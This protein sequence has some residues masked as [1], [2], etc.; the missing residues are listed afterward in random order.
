MLYGGPTEV[1]WHARARLAA[2][3]HAYIVG[4]YDSVILVHT[5]DI[6]VAIY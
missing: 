6:T 4:R 1:Q 3:V 5:V 2:G